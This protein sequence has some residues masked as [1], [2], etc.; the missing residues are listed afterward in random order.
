MAAIKL[1]NQNH[2]N[3][4]RLVVLLDYAGLKLCKEVLHAKEGLPEDGSQLY[5]HVLPFKK[6][7]QFKDMQEILCPPSKVTDESKFDL[8]LYMRLINVMFRG[9]YTLLIRDLRRNRHELIHLRD[10]SISD[11][12]FKRRWNSVC[13]MLQ[14]HGFVETFEDIKTGSLHTTEVSESIKKTTKGSV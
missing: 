10:K 5:Q 9:K 14:R 7:M 6:S 8:L 2:E 3:W 11:L 13:D 1:I 4:L 12:D